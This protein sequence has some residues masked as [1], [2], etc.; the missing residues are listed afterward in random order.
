[1]DDPAA[2]AK[3]REWAP[4]AL[5]STANVTTIDDETT[6]PFATWQA[7]GSP[8]YPNATQL[9]ALHAASEPSRSV[10]PISDD[11]MLSLELQPYGVAHVAI[12]LNAAAL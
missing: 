11:G 7:M 9:Q 3:L 5:P 6:N 10:V 1:M 8:Q 2:D 4:D 12:D